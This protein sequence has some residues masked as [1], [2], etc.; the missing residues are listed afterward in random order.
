MGLAAA[1]AFIEGHNQDGDGLT[2]SCIP[3]ALVLFNPVIDNGPG[4]YRYERVGRAYKNFSPP[5]NIRHGA[6]PT[7]LFLG[8]RDHLVPVETAAYYQRVMKKV[9]SRC[10]LHLYEG[11]GHVHDVPASGAIEQ[12]IATIIGVLANSQCLWCFHQLVILNLLSLHLDQGI[13]FQDLIC[14]NY[15]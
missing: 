13:L 1:T 2:V 14:S 15:K 8:T 12:V 6:P 11:Q 5:H 10:V 7:V 4:G 3:N 9:G